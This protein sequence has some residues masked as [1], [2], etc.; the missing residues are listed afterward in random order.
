MKGFFGSRKFLY[1]LSGTLFGFL[2]PIIATLL[3]C[4]ER[5]GS[6]GVKMVLEIQGSSYLYWII[7]TAPLWLG[8]L[9]LLLGL[10]SDRLHKEIERGRRIQEMLKSRNRVMAEDFASAKAVQDSFLPVVPDYK[11]AEIAYRY[12]PVSHV[13][14]DFLSITKF[15]DNSAGI[16]I[17]D[18]SGHGIS[19]ALINSMTLSLLNRI[20][21]V[22]GYNPAEY[23]STLNKELLNMI[24]GD[25][26]ISAI[27]TLLKYRE[28]GIELVLARAGHPYPL[29]WRKVSGKVELFTSGGTV[30][31]CFE[32]V[33]YENIH[34]NVSA[35]DTLFLYTDG[36]SELEK[37]DGEQ[38]GTE[39][40]AAL[41]EELSPGVSTVE[42]LLD[43]V[44]QKLMDYSRTSP[45]QDDMVIIAIRINPS[46]QP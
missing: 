39:G 15:Y 6:V 11:P 26:F 30:L 7:D 44:F 41:I 8:C 32:E 3:T 43:T 23:L 9:A 28:S 22:Y 25:K 27:F 16:F 37:G 10:K 5:Y 45:V 31:G 21:R 42:E 35:G 40:L 19:A 20:C 13:G 12:L 1:G 18:V 17:G 33:E 24:P 46:P 14:G 34:V 36:V 2:F 4:W 29:L 38:L